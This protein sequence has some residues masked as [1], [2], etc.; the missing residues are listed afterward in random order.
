MLQI[1]EMDPSQSI[2]DLFQPLYQRASNI[3]TFVALRN[4]ADEISRDYG[5]GELSNMT[6]AHLVIDIYMLLYLYL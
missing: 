3:Y 2:N 1:D 6:E 5:T 4:Q